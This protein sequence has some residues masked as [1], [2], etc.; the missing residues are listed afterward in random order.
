MRPTLRL[1]YP[2][3]EFLSRNSFQMKDRPRFLRYPTK[4][5]TL[6]DGSRRTVPYVGPVRTC[7]KN[8]VAFVGAI[9]MG[10]Q[11]LLG[12]IPM[13]DMDLVLTSARAPST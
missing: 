5:V 10:D 7:F 6:A 2:D 1:K 3:H 13:E 4:D 9:T 11:I 8:R 12:A